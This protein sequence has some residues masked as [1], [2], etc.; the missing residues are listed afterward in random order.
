MTDDGAGSGYWT[1]E[2]KADSSIA[3]SGQWLYSYS[4][5]SMTLEVTCPFSNGVATINGANMSFVAS[6]TAT[7]PNFGNSPFNL[8][9]TGTCSNAEGA[10][11]YVITFS[12]EGRADRL[13]GGWTATRTNG[14]GIKP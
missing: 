7:I 12:A 14:S 5:Y 6:G 3:V 13:E 9:V 8:T 1:F 10:G 4:I 11:T 2:Q